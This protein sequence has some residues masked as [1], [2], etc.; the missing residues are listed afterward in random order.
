MHPVQQIG[1]KAGAHTVNRFDFIQHISR[2][3]GTG[4]EFRIE[5]RLQ[6][7]DVRNRMPVRRIRF[8]VEGRLQAV[9]ITDDVRVRCVCLAGNGRG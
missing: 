3:V 7:R 4:G 1:I 6:V 5:R 8:V 2:S 9:D